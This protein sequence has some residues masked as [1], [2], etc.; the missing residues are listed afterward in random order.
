MSDVKTIQEWLNPLFPPHQRDPV[1]P[2]CW[3]IYERGRRIMLVYTLEEMRTATRPAERRAVALHRQVH[4]EE[5]VR[6]YAACIVDALMLPPNDEQVDAIMPLLL[7]LA[8]V[9]ATDSSNPKG[10]RE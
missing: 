1:E 7:T 3:E 2:T 8:R 10:E 5:T 9:P 6:E 4:T